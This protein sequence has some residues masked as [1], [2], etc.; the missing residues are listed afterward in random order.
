MFHGERDQ[1]VPYHQSR[2]LFDKL[3]SAGKDAR[4]FSFPHARHGTYLEMLSDADTQRGARQETTR[5]GRTTRPA[6]AHPTWQTVISFLRSEL[7]TG[8]R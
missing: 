2:L 8:G 3:A 4:F 7:H 6:P 5:D 1:L